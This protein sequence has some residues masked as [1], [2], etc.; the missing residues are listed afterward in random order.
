LHDLVCFLSQQ[1]VEKY[2]KSLLEE[3]A[4]HIPRT[5]NLVDVL[6]M[7]RP[8]FPTLRPLRRG[9][10]FLNDFAVEI[11]YPGEKATKRQAVAALRWASRVRT[12]VRQ[13]LGIRPPR[14]RKKK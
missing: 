11:R 14:R 3:L 2:L 12:T 7:A 6:D 4:I 9:A 8:H 1:S 10:F 5:H 13:L